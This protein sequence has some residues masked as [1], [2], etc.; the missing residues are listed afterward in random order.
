M[1]AP[2][3][4]IPV[5]VTSQPTGESDPTWTKLTNGGIF[6][7]RG[8]TAQWT[9]II[10]DQ[11]GE[12]IL[13]GVSD[14]TANTRINLKKQALIV[15]YDAVWTVQGGTFEGIVKMKILN[16][17]TTNPLIWDLD[18]HCVLRG[19]GDYQGQTLMLSYEGG[20]IPAPVW[21]G[22]LIKP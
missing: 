1:A 11:N 16:Y 12:A 18:I 22:V 17:D 14:N 21:E 19:T 7:A 9:F 20:I 8:K 10:R 2:A 3:E 5:T 4:K 13:E 6:Q 15:V